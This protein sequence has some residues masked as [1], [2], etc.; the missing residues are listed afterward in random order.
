MTSDVLPVA[1]GGQR[2]YTGWLRRLASSERVI[3]TGLYSVQRP[4]R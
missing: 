1:D 3:Y 4:A 2:H